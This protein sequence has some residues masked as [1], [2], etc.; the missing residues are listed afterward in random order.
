[1]PAHK[2]HATHRPETRFQDVRGGAKLYEA[3]K[4]EILNQLSKR[5]YWPEGMTI[6]KDYKKF[7]VANDLSFCG[8]AK[9]EH[10]ISRK[11]REILKQ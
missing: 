10:E 4:C 2:H 5:D 1:M 6:P 11:R 8:F 9:D 7:Y 3:K